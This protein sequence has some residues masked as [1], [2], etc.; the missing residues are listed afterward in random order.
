MDNELEPADISEKGWSEFGTV[1]GRPRRASDFNFE[2]AKR[3]ISLNSAT[4]IAITKL[5][6]RFPDCAGKTSF[7]ELNHDAKSF[8]KNIEGTLK[9]PVTILGTGPDKDAIIDRRK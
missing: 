7:E 2:L 8:I 9:I 6:I 5:D 3:A 1:T 4:Q